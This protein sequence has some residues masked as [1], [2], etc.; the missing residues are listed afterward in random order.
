MEEYRDLR[1]TVPGWCFII[2]IIAVL[3]DNH[4]IKISDITGSSYSSVLLA[5]GIALLITSPAISFFINTVSYLIIIL[6]WPSF[7]GH[8]GKT[9]KYSSSQ[10]E[11][12]V[13]SRMSYK[14]DDGFSDAFHKTLSRRWSYVVT[15]IHSATGIILGLLTGIII[16]ISKNPINIL[17]VLW[18][19]PVLIVVACLF[20]VY[21]SIIRKQVID[22]ENKFIELKERKPEDPQENKA[23]S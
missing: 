21:S 7:W 17:D 11:F 10:I 22:M 13:R 2:C 20:I 12:W 15:C 8:S 19:F 9:N 14:E 3:L 5:A 1:H 18:P 16:T 23:E 6:F 4:I